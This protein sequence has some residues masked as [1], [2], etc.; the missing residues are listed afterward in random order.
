MFDWSSSTGPEVT[1][2]VARSVALKENTE[3]VRAKYLHSVRQ[4]QAIAIKHGRDPTGA[5]A[6]MDIKA[7]A[8]I[9]DLK[10]TEAAI[11]EMVSSA[12]IPMAVNAA[13]EGVMD[14]VDGMHAALFAPAGLDVR[15]VGALAKTKEARAER[16]VYVDLV[17]LDLGDTRA[18][19]TLAKPWVQLVKHCGGLI[20]RQH[21]ANT[22]SHFGDQE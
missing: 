15:G 5:I 11:M 9:A 20:A 3:L 12:E 4:R 19:Q 21:H 17:A 7:T 16:E 13:V 18:G 1:P 22:S 2:S 6:S 14:A 10:A 8:T